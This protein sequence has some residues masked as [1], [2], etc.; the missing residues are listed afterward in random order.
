MGYYKKGSRRIL[1]YN[2][3]STISFTYHAEYVSYKRQ[4]GDNF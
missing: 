3:K 4:Y 2:Q 1:F